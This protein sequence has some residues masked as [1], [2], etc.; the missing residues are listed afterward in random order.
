[1]EMA[2]WILLRFTMTTGV[3]IEIMVDEDFDRDELTKGVCLLK[4]RIA[5]PVIHKKEICICMKKVM[6][7]EQITEPSIVYNLGKEQFN[8]T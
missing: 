7:L 3:Q 4:G 6:A 1:M 5:D 8:A 2:K